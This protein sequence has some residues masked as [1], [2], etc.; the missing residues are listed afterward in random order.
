MFHACRKCGKAPPLKDLKVE[1][2]GRGIP[3]SATYYCR[4][5]YDKKK[6]KEWFLVATLIV[7]LMVAVIFSACISN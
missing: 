3:P 5:C 4:K 6:K 2:F 1:Y 7:F